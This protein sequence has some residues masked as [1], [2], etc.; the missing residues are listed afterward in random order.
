MI[1]EMRTYTMK[2]GKVGFFESNFAEALPTRQQYSNLAAFWHTEL[3][4]LN[5]VI[6]VWPYKDLQ[7]R[8]DVRLAASND[9]SGKWPPKGIEEILN[10]ES[11]ILLPAPFM[12][13]L[14]APQVLGKVYELRIYTYQVGS[15]SRVLDIWAE[16]IPHR[17][18]Y[19]KLAACW[20]SDLGK[21]NRFF[22]LWAYD[23]FAHR[24][25]VRSEAAKDPNWPPPTS[26][27]LVNMENKILFPAE[28]SPL[29]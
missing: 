15:M 27:W 29:R 16:A 9:P 7:E 23:D 28:F 20:Y 10:M 14:V 4:P 6:H 24:D 19:S 17:E 3:G 1:Y 21:L 13:P 26:E 25:K 5:Q 12:N 8:A 22:H 11:E 2:T 18:K